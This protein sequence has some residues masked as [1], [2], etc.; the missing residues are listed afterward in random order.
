MNLW[1]SLSI[2]HSFR[3]AR[4]HRFRAPHGRRNS[5][6]ILRN[7]RVNY[8]SYVNVII[9]APIRTYSESVSFH[10]LE[11]RKPYNHTDFA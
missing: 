9:F 7:W 8:I 10:H 1:I 6:H 4:A 2:S 5:G 3:E 11:I